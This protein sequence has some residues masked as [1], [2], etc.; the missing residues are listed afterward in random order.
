M[1]EG[2]SLSLHVIVL[3]LPKKINDTKPY[4]PPVSHCFLFL[5][6]QS[7]LIDQQGKQLIAEAVYLYGVMLLLMD[8]NID[9]PVRERML[10]SYYR[11]KVQSMFVHSFF[12]E[13]EMEI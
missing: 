13:M 10:M 7:I 6:R 8:E 11:Y 12:K 4:F 9:G 5:L 1:E 2:E 3:S